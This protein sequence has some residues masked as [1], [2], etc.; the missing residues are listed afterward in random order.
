MRKC[1]LG[2]A[3]RLGDRLVT[4]SIAIPDTIPLRYGATQKRQAPPLGH[5]GFPGEEPTV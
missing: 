1:L 5:P 3:L 2:I 4:Q